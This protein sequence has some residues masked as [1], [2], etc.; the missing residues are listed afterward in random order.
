MLTGEEGLGSTKVAKLFSSYG[1]GW[2]KHVNQL[3]TINYT[4]YT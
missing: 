4:Q 2:S 1:H 3:K